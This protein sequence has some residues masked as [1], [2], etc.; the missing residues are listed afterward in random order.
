[1]TSMANLNFKSEKYTDDKTVVID[2]YEKLEKLPSDEPNCHGVC[3]CRV[4]KSLTWAKPEAFIPQFVGLGPYHHFGNELI[5]TDELKLGVAK[6]VLEVQDLPNDKDLFL[7]QLQNFLPHIQAFY[8]HADVNFTY[9]YRTLLYILTVDG[10]FLLALLHNGAVLEGRYSSFYVLTGKHYG[11]PLVNAAGVELTLDGIMRDI[12]MLENQIPTHVLKQISRVNVSSKEIQQVDTDLGLTMLNFCEALCPLVC[13]R[14]L[15]KDPEAYDH[16]LD[17]MYHLIEVSEL[18]PQS[19]SEPE[20]EPEP[21]PVGYKCIWF[22]AFVTILCLTIT[23]LLVYVIAFIWG[24]IISFFRYLF[25]TIQWAFGPLPNFF[26]MLN[27]GIDSFQKSLSRKETKF[28]IYKPLR[29]CIGQIKENVR[30]FFQSQDLTKW[31]EVARPSAMELH[32]AG[33]HLQPIEGGISFI[34]FDEEI[35]CK[36]FYLPCIRVN[37]ISEVIITNLMAYE[38]LTKSNC[39]IFSWYIELMSSLIQTHEDVKLLVREKIIYKTQLSDEDVVQIFN[40]MRKIIK[41]NEIPKLE[42]EIK[43]LNAEF[44]VKWYN[45]RNPVHY[46]IIFLMVFVAITFG[47]IAATQ[48]LY[49]AFNP[50]TKLCK[51]PEA[52]DIYGRNNDNFIS[53]M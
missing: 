13:L 24:L 51:P 5:M 2:I 3:V 28:P 44:K 45:I 39:L 30:G 35:N 21:R 53:S 19:K 22:F 1:M 14:K 10:L 33:I 4:P 43:K 32:K 42:E 9:D 31:E 34:K 37:V 18:E 36:K 48:M 40:G 7:H 27:R 16:L 20:P 8:H 29:Q 17:L 50:T 26:H 52:G 38:S 15:S 6:R 46:Q 12:F 25:R 41:S 11:M 47:V 23:T 49:C